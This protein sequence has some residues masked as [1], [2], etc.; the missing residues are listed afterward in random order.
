MWHC[1]YVVTDNGVQDEGMVHLAC[2][3]SGIAAAVV[4][5]D[6]WHSMKRITDK[7]PFRHPLHA[8][9]LADLKAAYNN[10]YAADGTP[11]LFI[12]NM[13]DWLAK[14]EA[15]IPAAS[16]Q[17][18]RV[19]I[20][21]VSHLFAH[22]SFLDILSRFGTNANERWHAM[23]KRICLHAGNIRPDHLQPLLA[24][25]A[26]RFNSLAK[27]RVRELEWYLHAS[28]AD[29]ALW[30]SLFQPMLSL[31]LFQNATGCPF[32]LIATPSNRSF[33]RA[34]LDALPSIV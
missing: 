4:G 17:A 14:Y 21:K 3:Q 11:E 16:S 26:Y 29:R 28:D 18:A 20:G 9:I 25:N 7:I 10:V 13:N 23:L 22:K 19:Q 2:A 15:T 12:S 8:N 31:P 34:D 27:A 5:D 32:M 6:C 1:Q 30:E 24:W 33:T